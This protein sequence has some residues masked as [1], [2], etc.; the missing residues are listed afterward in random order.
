MIDNKFFSILSLFFGIVGLACSAVI[1]SFIKIHQI[2]NIRFG[3]GP[4]FYYAA[5]IVICFVLN[6]CLQKKLNTKNALS[7]LGFWAGIISLIPIFLFLFFMFFGI[8]IAPFVI[9]MLK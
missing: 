7:R 1:V 6:I 5:L 3:N 9:L 4:Y 8:F 2:H